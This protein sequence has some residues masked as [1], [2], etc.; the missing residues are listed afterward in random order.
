[1][2][3]LIPFA[4]TPLSDL[5]KVEA[6]VYTETLE[7]LLIEYKVSGPLHQLIFPVQSFVESRRDELWKATCLE[8]FFSTDSAASTPY[9]EMNCAPN[10]DW[11]AY[12]FSSYRQGMKAS[13]D[14]KVRLIHREGSEEEVLFRVRIEGASLRGKKWASLT[15][16][17]QFQ[18]GTHSYWAL[19]H[20]RPQPDF[21]DKGAFI[22]P[23]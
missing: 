6:E 17:L 22:A 18:D 8:A 12:E 2:K 14:L 3:T 20:P 9:I 10:G 11:N 5:F 1:M 7:S 19:K 15:T 13:E 23:L 16:I 21:H 4:N